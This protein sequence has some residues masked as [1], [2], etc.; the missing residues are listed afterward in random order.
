MYN[1]RCLYFGEMAERSKAA[2]LK[3][4]VVNSYLGFESLSLRQLQPKS[5]TSIWVVFLK[6]ANF[7]RLLQINNHYVCTNTI[8]VL[9]YKYEKIKLFFYFNDMF[10]NFSF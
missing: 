9:S 5:N 3:T 7:L 2:V 6:I 4:V 8:F 10:V 1:N